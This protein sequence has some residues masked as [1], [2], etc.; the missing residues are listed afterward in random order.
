MTCD[1]S[2]TIL[3]VGHGNSAVVRDGDLTIVVD[4]GGADAG[5]RLLEYL[6]SEGVCVID[7][8]FLSHADEDHIGSAPT[9]LLASDMRVKKVF[10]NA[11]ATKRTAAFGNLR[12]AIQTARRERATTIATSLTTEQSRLLSAPNLVMEI[13]YPSPESTLSGPGGKSLDGAPQSTNSL[14]AVI[15]VSSAGMVRVLLPGDCDSS[16]LAFWRDEPID[17]SADVVV[18]PHH[19]GRPGTESPDTFARAFVAATRPSVVIF[20]MHVSKHDLPRDDVTVAI[21]DVQPSA[22]LI[23][24]Q[25]P[26]RLEAHS[27]YHPWIRHSSPTGIVRKLHVRVAMLSG[28]IS[29]IED[30]NG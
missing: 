28:D 2:V 3:N 16:A 30:N 17:P 7:A 8:L 13:L 9:L 10:V 22:Q 20:S 23:C 26:K 19:G 18:F 11:D 21:C 4:T 24:T 12:L 15:R 5:G 25:L 29:V 6:R 27:G 14:S 1:P